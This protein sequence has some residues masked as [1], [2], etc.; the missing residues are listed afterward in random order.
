MSDFPSLASVIAK[1][2]WTRTSTVDVKCTGCDWTADL[3][4]TDRASVDLVAEHV[5][6]VWLELRTIRKLDHLVALPVGAT[7]IDGFGTTT[8]N[9]VTRMPGGWFGQG[10]PWPLEWPAGGPEIALLI[11][12]PDWLRP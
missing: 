10:V 9:V 8:E 11:H 7:V 4:N 3:R 5:E 1:H 12:H 6:Q 2:R